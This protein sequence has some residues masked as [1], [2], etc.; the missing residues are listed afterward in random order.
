MTGR[1]AFEIWSANTIWAGWVRPVPFV[2]FDSDN[3]KDYALT[4]FTIPGINYINN[5][6]TDTA[7]ILDL[8]GSDSV[9][10]GLALSKLG[11]R[12]IPLYNGTNEQ[13]GA[14]ALVDNHN[15]ETALIWGASELKPISIPN[16]AP[17]VF[18]LDSNRTNRYKM[19]VSVFDNSWDLYRQD[20]PSAELFLKQGIIKILI[21]GDRVQKDLIRIFYKFQREG[22]K[23]YFTNG[24]EKAKEVSLRKPPRKYR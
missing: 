18:L 11:W 9:K 6:Q 2:A 14:M 5:L 13:Q 20:I 15:I 22:I 19:N 10:E 17:P 3:I 24:F 8:C 12:P 16:N 23:I 21:R 7:I 1:Q 4:N